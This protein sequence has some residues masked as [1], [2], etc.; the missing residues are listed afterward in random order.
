MDKSFRRFFAFIL[1]LSLAGCE[2]GVKIQ[3]LQWSATGDHIAVAIKEKVLFLEGDAPYSI[4]PIV[5]ENISSPALTW[6]PLSNKLVV[7]THEHKGWDL[8]LFDVRSQKQTYL[9]EDLAKDFYPRY[10]NAEEI[11]FYS[12]REAQIAPWLYMVS[13]KQIISYKER[14]P[15]P[16]KEGLSED[17]FSE[18][19][20]VKSGKGSR[21]Q[22][23]YKGKKWGWKESRLELSLPRWA[24]DNKRCAFVARNPEIMKDDFV[25]ILDFEGRKSSWVPIKPL[26]FLTFADFFSKKGEW[27]KAFWFDEQFLKHYPEDPKG[28]A[29]Y[30]RKAYFYLQEEPDLEQVKRVLTTFLNKFSEVEG[31]VEAHFWLGVTFG[32]EKKWGDAASH[33]EQSLRLSPE[34][35][36]A[37]QSKEFLAFLNSNKVPKELLQSFFQAYRAQEGPKPNLALLGYKRVV[38]NNNSEILGIAAREKL[39]KLY[40]SKREFKKALT[41]WDKCFQVL[42]SPENKERARYEMA[43]LLEKSDKPKKAASI[44]RKVN[45]P[46]RERA[47]K[48]LLYL[49]QQELFDFA[50]SQIVAETFL[51][52]YPESLDWDDIYDQWDNLKKLDRLLV[53]D[54]ALTHFYKARHLVERGEDAKALKEFE[55]A[56]SLAK[57]PFFKRMIYLE[58]AELSQEPEEFFVSMGELLKEEKGKELA[59]VYESYLKKNPQKEGLLWGAAGSALGFYSEREWEKP[60]GRNKEIL[61]FAD[62]WIEAAKTFPEKRGA[63]RESLYSLNNQMAEMAPGSDWEGEMTLRLATFEALDAFYVLSLKHLKR[64]KELAKATGNKT[65]RK[66]AKRYIKEIKGGKK[67][68]SLLTGLVDQR[69]DDLPKEEVQKSSLPQKEW[70]KDLQKAE[71]L[72]QKEKFKQAKEFLRPYLNKKTIPREILRLYWRV[73]KQL[74]MSS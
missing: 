64:V 74:E 66:Q 60:N 54:K 65:L 34:G 38:K 7:T 26:H 13:S 70:E 67:P 29:A 30:L 55:K 6:S 21:I 49:S 17:L 35:R 63:I 12:D 1:F 39:A 72:F 9:T 23:L 68:L 16:Q 11:L 36:R 32:L 40:E 4:D 73:Q 41:V 20:I 18:I 53:S 61:L 69:S 43:L 27:D 25:L 15:P 37:L 45:D 24:P 2:E 48:Q 51:K 44:Y 71:A 14:I 33:F 58:S 59:Q 3:E 28:S 50:Q 52:K 31:S 8:L 10:L 19:K 56:L 47:L 5:L 22:G 42:K 46:Y 57:E 62:L